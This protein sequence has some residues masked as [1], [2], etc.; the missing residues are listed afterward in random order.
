M[1]T[2]A[3]FQ[4]EY[5][6]FLDP[7]GKVVDALPAFATDAAK[8]VELYR[9]MVLMR[10]FD[11]KAIALQRTGKLGT[12]A[13]CL[14]Q[15]AVARRHRRV[16]ASRGRVRCRAY[17]ENGAQFMRGV[18]P[19]E[20][21]LYWG[22]DERG[23]DFAGPRT[24]FPVCVP[25]AT[26][27]LHAAGAALGVQAAQ[28]RPRVAVCMLRRRRLPPRAISTR[29]MNVAG[30]W[31][32]PLVC[33][34]INNQWAISVPRSAQTARADAG[35]EGASP[36]AS[37]G[38]QVDGNDVIAVRD[39]RRAGAGQARAQRRRRQRDRGA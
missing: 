14:G 10:T 35:A 17:R 34:V 30:A 20:V 15:E 36:P 4:I 12:Y 7:Q 23:S 32:L 11:A 24:T 8:L 27:C 26:Q 13:S 31:Q 25:I 19:R 38:V 28:A 21:L 39:A 37:H 1:T 9:A 3:S 29:R 16:D 6:Q 22:G 18:T 5:L 33:V 2:A